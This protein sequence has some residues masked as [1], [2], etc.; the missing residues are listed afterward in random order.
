MKVPTSNYPRNVCLLVVLITYSLWRIYLSVCLFVCLY[1]NCCQ[2]RDKKNHFQNLF[3]GTSLDLIR[4]FRFSALIVHKNIHF[5][6]GH[7]RTYLYTSQTVNNIFGK[8]AMRMSAINQQ[9]FPALYLLKLNH[10]KHY[11]THFTLIVTHI[12]KS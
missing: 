5:P 1:E 6:Y 3:A 9:S 10:Y 8:F 12:R 7:K 4:K 2:Y 11:I